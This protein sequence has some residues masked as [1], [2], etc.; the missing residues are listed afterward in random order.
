MSV[1]PI[2]SWPPRGY[3]RQIILRAFYHRTGRTAKEDDPMQSQSTH[4]ARQDSDLDWTQLSHPQW[5]YTQAL[6]GKCQLTLLCDKYP[7]QQTSTSKIPK[8]IIYVWDGLKVIVKLKGAATYAFFGSAIMVGSAGAERHHRRLTGE[9]ENQKIIW[10]L[11]LNV[12]NMSILKAI[13]M[14]GFGW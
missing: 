1:L 12:H 3:G 7:N 13:K 2:I 6:L 8:H 11:V 10:F 9:R 4:S 5:S 14:Q